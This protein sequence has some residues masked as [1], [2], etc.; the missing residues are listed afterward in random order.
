MLVRFITVMAGSGPQQI[1]PPHAESVNVHQQG[2]LHNLK[3]GN[4]VDNQ[5]E[6]SSQTLYV[7]R[8]GYRR[9][10]YLVHE[11]VDEKDLQR[12]IEDLKRKLCRA[13]RK[14]TP[15]SSD[16][17]SNDEGDASYRECS[18]TP[19]SASYSYEEEHSHKRK[20]KSPSGKGVGTKVMKKA[21]SQISKSPFTQGIEKA[22]LPRRFHQPT[23]TMY[24]GRTDPVEHVSQ[25]KQKMAVHSQDEALLCRVFPSSLGPMPMRWFNG[26]RTNSINSFKKLT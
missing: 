20:R 4:H 15:S 22:K 8:S 9:R 13:Q 26:L 5:Q 21:L 16:V 1:S 24:N 2:E 17:S 14:Q 7:G 6:G 11:Q 12:E 3:H 25:F 18:E 23:F 10:S 19:P